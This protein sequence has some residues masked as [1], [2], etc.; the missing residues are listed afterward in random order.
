MTDNQYRIYVFY[1]HIDVAIV[2]PLTV[3]YSPQPPKKK[4]TCVSTIS[5]NLRVFIAIFGQVLNKADHSP[6]YPR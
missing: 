3:V 5:T 4:T 1:T 6:V 2:L